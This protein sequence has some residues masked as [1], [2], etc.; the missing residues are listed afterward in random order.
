M[1]V[2]RD[3][4]LDLLPVYLAGEASPDTRALVDAYLERDPELAHIAKGG[5][6]EVVFEPP[7]A[8]LSKEVE[9]LT[10]ERTRTMLRLRSIL[11]AVALFFS[12]LPLAGYDVGRHRWA[13]ISDFPAGAAVCV[14]LGLAAWGA[15]FAVRRRL[16]VTGL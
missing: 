4:I 14:V 12:L 1:N 3:V 8:P 10:I 5:L 16:R 2:T 6:H 15:Y 13:M 9:L 7:P 11:L